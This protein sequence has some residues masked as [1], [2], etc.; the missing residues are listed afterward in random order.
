MYTVCK[1][2]G[3]WIPVIYIMYHGYQAKLLCIMDSSNKYCISWI[4]EINIVYVLVSMIPD[5][6]VTGSSIQ[7]TKHKYCQS[8]IQDKNI[9][10]HGYQTQILVI[11]GI[12]TTVILL[13]YCLILLN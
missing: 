13:K 10:Y 5:H 7:S 4:P 2:Y 12:N 9:V 11:P 1:H 3:S 6:L 8:W